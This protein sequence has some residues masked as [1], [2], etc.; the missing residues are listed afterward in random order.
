MNIDPYECRFGTYR[1]AEPKDTPDIAALLRSNPMHGSIRTFYS[2][3]PD[4]FADVNLLGKSALILARSPKQI[5]MMLYEMREY[6]VFFEGKPE[7]AVYLGLLRVA[8]AFRNRIGLLEHGFFSLRYFAD[9]LDLAN[10]FY[11]SIAVDNHPA[12]RL[13]EAGL[14]CLPRYI[15]Q[16]TLHTLLLSTG[17]AQQFPNLPSP[18]AITPANPDDA[19]ELAALLTANTQGWNYATALTVQ[20]LTTLVSARASFSFSDIA[21]LR[22]NGLAVGCAGVWDQRA[23]RQQQI[24]GYASGLNLLRPLYNLWAG[25]KRTPRLPAAGNRL[26]LVF[27][28]FFCLEGR[29][30]SMADT[31]LRYC[32]HHAAAKGAHICAL[33]FS[34]QNP[35]L[36][37]LTLPRYSYHTRIYQVQIPG[38]RTRTTNDADAPQPE[39]ALL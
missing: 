25:M 2:R 5:P 15:P 31:L 10:N 13:L 20:S 7:Q 38:S 37:R 23:Y 24:Q 3:E 18:Y 6:P 33:G 21:I 17:L 16:G 29:H 1:I 27:L 12:R 19:A 8:E 22:H 36:P 35:I 11:T 9:R 32:L 39:I 26:E 28:P 30:V 4:F 34:P 14:S